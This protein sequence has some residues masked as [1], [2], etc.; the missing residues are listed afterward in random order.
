MWRYI[1]VFGMLLCA[2]AQSARGDCATTLPQNP[3]FSPPAPYPTRTD[4]FWYGSNDLWLQ[5]SFSGHWGVAPRTG[6]KLFVWKQGYDVRREPKPSLIVTGKRLDG[7]AP[8]LA[9]AGGT[10]AIMGNTAA[11]LISVEFP[12]E[13]CWELSVYH[14]GHVLT[15]V[16]SVGP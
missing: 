4:G 6:Q 16:V 2:E 7:E 1:L 8:A 11:M 5:L 9:V 10:N 15:F 3:P 12:T 14:A 13:G